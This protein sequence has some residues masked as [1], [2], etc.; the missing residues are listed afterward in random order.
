MTLSVRKAVLIILAITTVIS[1]A[2][3][4]TTDPVVS[5]PSFEILPPPAGGAYQFCRMWNESPRDC[6]RLQ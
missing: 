2:C 4:D 3:Q 6:R 1:A 5:G